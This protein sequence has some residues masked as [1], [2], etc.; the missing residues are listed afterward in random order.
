MKKLTFQVASE[1]AV[2]ME[3][4]YQNELAFR[5]SL[6]PQPRPSPVTQCTVTSASKHGG[7][8][9][10]NKTERRESFKNGECYRCGND[11]EAQSCPFKKSVCQKCT[12]MGHS[13]RKYHSGQK[14]QPHQRVCVWLINLVITPLLWHL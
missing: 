5:P 14:N 12:E 8:K 6:P 9:R 13:A 1:T 2:A 7:R 10:F 4:T 3:M 11:H